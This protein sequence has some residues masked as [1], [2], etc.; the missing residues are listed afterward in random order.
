MS[1]GNTQF[2]RQTCVFN[3]S[4]AAGSSA[5]VMAGDCNV[6]SLRLS[7]AHTVTVSATVSCIIIVIIN[8]RRRHHHHH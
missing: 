6:L 8:R 1:L 5:A 4:P 3:T 7:T 2:P